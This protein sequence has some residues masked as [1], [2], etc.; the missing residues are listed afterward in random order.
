V[1]LRGKRS[2]AREPK[3]GNEQTVPIGLK[4][5]EDRRQRQV[6]LRQREDRNRE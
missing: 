2:R 1:D 6:V 4:A 5:T 3:R